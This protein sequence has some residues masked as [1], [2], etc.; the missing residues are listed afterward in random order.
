MIPECTGS[1]LWPG[2]FEPQSRANQ[3]CSS[4]ASKAEKVSYSVQSPCCLRLVLSLAFSV[5]G[6][7]KTCAPQSH[8]AAVPPLFSSEIPFLRAS[9]PDT[10]II[11]CCNHRWSRWAGAHV[12]DSHLCFTAILKELGFG[13]I[14]AEKTMPVS[15]G[16]RIPIIIH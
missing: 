6:F 16:R 4:K 14:R 15:A 3:S 11:S 7:I 8:F 2:S 1:L 12:S 9:K 13:E 5:H 10:K